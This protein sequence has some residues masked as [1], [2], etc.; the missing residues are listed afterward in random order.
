MRKGERSFW[1]HTNLNIAEYTHRIIKI[2]DGRIISDE[3]NPTESRCRSVAYSCF[4][5][6][7]NENK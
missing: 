7:A 5:E 6:V 3:L 1:L 4:S 2:A